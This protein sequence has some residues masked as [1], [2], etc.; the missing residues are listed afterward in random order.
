[1]TPLPW[2]RGYAAAPP[3]NLSSQLFVPEELVE[4]SDQ[5]QPS[6]D[7]ILDSDIPILPV[8]IS[9]AALAESEV[10]AVAAIRNP[11]PA[12]KD[13]PQSDMFL[14]LY[15]YTAYNFAFETTSTVS[16]SPVEPQLFIDETTSADTDLQSQS[17]NSGY[18]VD[19]MLSFDS[20]RSGEFASPL[21]WFGSTRLTNL[22][23][24]PPWLAF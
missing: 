9:V 15:R 13:A 8:A 23:N 1:M 22:L 16:S 21:L 19:L 10:T 2:W 7:S 3:E 6:P 17:K 11:N 14:Q 20:M 5:D 12:P 24:L 18:I 4:N